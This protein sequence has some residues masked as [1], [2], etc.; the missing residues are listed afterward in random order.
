[1]AKLTVTIA[2]SPSSCFTLFPLKGPGGGDQLEGPGGGD[3]F[4]RPGGSTVVVEAGLATAEPAALLIIRFARKLCFPGLQ[5][6]IWAARWKISLDHFLVLFPF[7]LLT[8]STHPF[9][10]CGQHL[11]RML[12]ETS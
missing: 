4:K 12:P 7:S 5:L 1:M 10:F 2:G 11:H 6:E 3:Q 9:R 8:G